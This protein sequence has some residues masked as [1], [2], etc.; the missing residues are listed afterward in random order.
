[1]IFPESMKSTVEIFVAKFEKKSKLKEKE[2]ELRE[3]DLNIQERRSELEEKER[4]HRL[5]MD[6]EERRAFLDILKSSV[7]SGST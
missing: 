3:R 7:K 2:L 1:M 4:K 5:Q 6:L